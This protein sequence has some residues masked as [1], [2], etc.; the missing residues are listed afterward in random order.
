MTIEVS[1]A[2][3]TSIASIIVAITTSIINT[4]VLAKRNEDIEKLKFDLERKKINYQIPETHTIKRLA[5]LDK[6]ISA[7]QGIKDLLLT[8]CEG[9]ENSLLASIGF[10]QYKEA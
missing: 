3:I 4:K 5:A 2:L 8:F 10:R 9:P 1:I 6:H 7:I